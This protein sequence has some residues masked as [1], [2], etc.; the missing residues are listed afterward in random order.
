MARLPCSL[1]AVVALL[2]CCA[3]AA[4]SSGPIGYGYKLVGLD[5]LN[6]DDGVVGHLELIR[7][8]ETFGKDIKHLKLVARYDSP[9]P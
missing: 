2:F 1:V 7:G 5:H 3:G 6:R 9:V 4:A 8:T